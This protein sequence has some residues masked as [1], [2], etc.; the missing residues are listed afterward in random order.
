MGETQVREARR[1]FSE[2][3]VPHFD[4]PELSV[5]AFSY[6]AKYQRNQQL[7]L[8]VPAPLADT[9]APDVE[10]SRLIIEAA[11]AER[12]EVLTGLESRALLTAFGCLVKVT[13]PDVSRITT[14]ETQFMNALLGGAVTALTLVVICGLACGLL[15]ALGSILGWGFLSTIGIHLLV[16]LA[17]GITCAITLSGWAPEEWYPEWLVRA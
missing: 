4:T 17:T 1:L 5:E 9:S 15:I 10:G 3:R 13:Y 8:Q 7:L 12:R 16:L 14:K 11:I 6:L 2:E